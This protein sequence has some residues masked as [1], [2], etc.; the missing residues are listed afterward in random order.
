MLKN[1]YYD[2][3][4]IGK[5]KE[6][7]HNYGGINMNGNE[8]LDK[9]LELQSKGISID[10]ISKELGVVTKTLKGFL[11]KRGYKLKNGKYVLKEEKEI[12]QIAFMDINEKNNK[13][14]KKKS[15]EKKATVKKE[16]V[17]K[18]PKKKTTAK[19]SVKDTNI[20][21][22][23]TKRAQPKKDRKIN[24]TQEDMDKLCE[25][26]DWYMQIKDYK[27]IKPKKNNKKDVSIDKRELKDLKSTSIKVDKKTWEDFER[28]CSNSQFTKT[29]ILTQ[30]LNDF[31]NEYK[32]LL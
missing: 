15:V 23:K 24:I 28:I 14:N 13:D 17:V 30:A 25:V 21:K 7:M 32:H 18:S 8:R 5:S 27:A 10:D 9:F 16:D 19:N 29:E 2:T 3:I 31:M 26:Y 22:G 20:L 4:N 12:N 11:N 1:I 6:P